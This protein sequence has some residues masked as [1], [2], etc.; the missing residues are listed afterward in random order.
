MGPEREKAWLDTFSALLHKLTMW[1]GASLFPPFSLSIYKT[2]VWGQSL[3]GFPALTVQN[4]EHSRFRR[5]GAEVAEDRVRVAKGGGWAGGPPGLGSIRKKPKF[6][7]WT[8]SPDGIIF[9]PRIYTY[10]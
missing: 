7:L 8:P 3:W 4:I 10:L 5:W 6:R 9:S 2:K 1:P